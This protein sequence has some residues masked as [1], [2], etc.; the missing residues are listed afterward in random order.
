MGL[1][2]VAEGGKPDVPGGEAKEYPGSLRLQKT[3]SLG[4][5]A[6]RNLQL[7]LRVY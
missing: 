3:C 4:N 7:S 5:L 1:W 2:V 6:Y